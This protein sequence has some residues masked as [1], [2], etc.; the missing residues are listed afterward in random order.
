MY[1]GYKKAIE[2]VNTLNEG[3]WGA[4]LGSLVEPISEYNIQI[5]AR[6][7]RSPAACSLREIEGLQN[8]GTRNP[9]THSLQRIPYITLNFER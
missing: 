7:Q 1:A 8:I 6:C 3:R 4:V 5:S 9:L 2:S